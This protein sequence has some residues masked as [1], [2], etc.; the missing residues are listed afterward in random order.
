MK[1][2]VNVT[3]LSGKKQQTFEISHLVIA[4]W[5]GRDKEAMEHHIQEL[6]ALGIKRPTQTPTFYRVAANRL[7]TDSAIEC[8]G[9]TS[10]GEVETII[11]AQD[12]KLYVGLSSDH[13]DREVEAYGITISKQ[14]CDKPVASEVWPFE[15]VAAHW[16]SLIVRSWLTAKGERTLYQ[17]G[18]VAS[19]LDPKDVI[20]RYTGSAELPDGSAILGGTMPAIGGIRYGERFE[21]ELEDPVLSRKL[22]LVYDITELPISG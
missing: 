12:G 17:E 11:I 8:S 18:T 20:A 1:I 22:H 6:E 13:T 9:G 21:C 7:T 15:E 2:D 14:V 19:L 4:G 16:D 3:S 5:A 10:S